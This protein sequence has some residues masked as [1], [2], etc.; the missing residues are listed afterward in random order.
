LEAMQILDPEHLP[1]VDSSQMLIP[2]FDEFGRRRIGSM[3][4][5]RLVEHRA[6]DRKVH[7]SIPMIVDATCQR[8]GVTGEELTGRS[9]HRR[10]SLARAVIAYLARELTTLSYPEIARAMGRNNHSSVHAGARR[11][12]RSIDSEPRIVLDGH[13]GGGDTIDLVQLLDGLRRTI[14]G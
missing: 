3:T 12:A 14:R 2:G 10:I 8:L 4:I 9:R 5:Q 7:V 1:H 13:K 6:L 11:L